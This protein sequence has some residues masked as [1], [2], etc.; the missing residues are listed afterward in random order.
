MSKKI[1]TLAFVFLISVCGFS[2]SLQ[3]EVQH[4]DIAGKLFRNAKSKNN[5]PVGSPYLQQAFLSANVEDLNI[6]AFMRYNVFNDEFEFITPKN[7]TLILDKIEDFGKINFPG[8][9]KKYRLVVYTDNGRLTNGYLIELHSKVDYTLY[10]KEN[11]G[12]TEEKI[13]KTTLESAMPAK[14]TKSV[15]TYFLKAASGNT[16]EFPTG[17]K[18]LIKMFPD[19]K[20]AIETYL[21]TNKINFDNESDLIKIVD[22]LAAP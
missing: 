20:Q 3:K 9:Q 7:D 19:K 6:K 13:A 11:I 8:L 2:Q 1:F 18:A 17:K 5:K 15:D 4:P 12:F 22:F 16:T 21:K 10:K 14:Y